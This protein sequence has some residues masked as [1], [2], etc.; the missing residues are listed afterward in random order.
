MASLVDSLLFCN[1]LFAGVSA[2]DFLFDFLEVSQGPL[3]GLEIID[4]RPRA[5]KGNT[6]LWYAK[7]IPSANF[8]YLSGFFSCFEGV[9]GS[10]LVTVTGSDTQVIQTSG[11]QTFFNN[12]PPLKKKF[13]QVPP[14]QRQNYLLGKKCLYKEVQYSLSLAPSVSDLLKQHCNWE[15]LKCLQSITKFMANQF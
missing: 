1:Y 7:V 11:S 15:T 2:I 6:V 8:I 10:L 9:N 3:G 4:N 13:S 14:D 12:V 5:G